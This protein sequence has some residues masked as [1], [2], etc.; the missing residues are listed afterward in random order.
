MYN[1]CENYRHW[2]K[3]EKGNRKIKI[4]PKKTGENGRKKQRKLTKKT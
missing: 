3:K 1:V 2:L 4:K